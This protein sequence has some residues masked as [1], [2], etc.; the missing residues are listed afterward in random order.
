MEKA[1][2]TTVTVDEWVG[3]FR[4]IGLSDEQMTAWHA[5]FEARYPE[6]HE[7][8]LKG[9]GLPPERIAA[10]RLSARK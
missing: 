2:K 1:M 5:A 4:E 10:I 6:A 3:L 7:T 8:F 9:L